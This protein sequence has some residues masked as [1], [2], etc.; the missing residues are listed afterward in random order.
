[1][2]DPNRPA[3]APGMMQTMGA[4]SGD[5]QRTPTMPP[6]GGMPGGGISL[7]GMPP[8]PGG[9]PAMP[10]GMPGVGGGLPGMGPGI[11]AR[12]G[13]PEPGSFGGGGFGNLMNN[14]NIPQQ[15]RDYL[16]ALMGWRDARPEGRD[17]RQEW[18]AARPQ[19]NGGFGRGSATAQGIAVGEPNPAAPA[20]TMPAGGVGSSLTVNG[21]TPGSGF[22]LPGY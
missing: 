20:G 19:F 1:M 3:P 9:M 15:V 17:G 6:S 13:M 21:M 16:T 10:G 8:V 4:L 11:P 14:P 18:R 5:P 22:D 12:P 7:G 2:Y